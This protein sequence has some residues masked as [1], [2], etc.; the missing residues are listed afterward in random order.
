MMTK[1]QQTQ[2]KNDK[3]H[4]ERWY[5]QLLTKLSPRDYRRLDPCCPDT[6]QTRPHETA[7]AYLAEVFFHQHGFILKRPPKGVLGDYIDATGKSY[8]IMGP[9]PLACFNF[10]NI[11]RQILRHTQKY[12][13][14]I[15]NLYGLSKLA[16]FQI[17]QFVKK[18]GLP[19]NKFY[20]L[21]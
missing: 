19:E 8:D 11:S 7:S 15:V 4:I 14:V 17:K 3:N 20:F 16:R 10:R 12:D 13:R 21:F 6:N 1:V 18:Q 5:Q 9:F 2:L